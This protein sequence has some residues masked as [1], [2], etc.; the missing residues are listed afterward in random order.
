M[1]HK[2]SF[3]PEYGIW[4]GM[5]QRCENPAAPAYK[6]YGGR[7]I[8]VCLRWDLFTSFMRD[9]GERP[10]SKHSIDRINNNGNYEPGNC[11]WATPKQ[12][13]SNKSNSRLLMWAGQTQTLGAWAAEFKVER[14]VV[15]SRAN[16]GL[17]PAQIFGLRPIPTAKRDGRLPQDAHA[18][19]VAPEAIQKLHAEREVLLRHPGTMMR[20]VELS[21]RIAAYEAST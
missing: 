3:M 1:T 6:Y 14:S 11:R 18:N 12:Q 21:K 8:E 19:P 16:R 13:A 9:M 17:A 4:H 10:S 2:A 15:Y 7:G 5:H 20:V